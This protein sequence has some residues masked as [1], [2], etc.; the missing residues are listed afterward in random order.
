MN[1]TD[2]A[3]LK[4]YTIV[5]QDNGYGDYNRDL[6]LYLQSKLAERG[7]NIPIMPD[8]E[9][10][11]E[12]EILIGH[13]NREE[14]EA[15]YTGMFA[16][17]IMH[18]T[19]D[20]VGNKY[21]LAGYEWFSTKKAIDIA[22]DAMKGGKTIQDCRTR[23]QPMFGPAPQREGKY[24][25]LHYNILVE[26]VNWG[27]GGILEGPVYKR[28]EPMANIVLDHAPDFI[29]FCE[30][31]E[32]WAATLPELFGHK[33]S[34]VCI[35]RA[36]NNA[37]NRTLVAYDRK[38]FRLLEG[39]YENI[40]AVPSINHRVMTWGLLEERET[41]KHILVCGTHWES[42]PRESDRQKQAIMCAELINQKSAQYNAEIILMGD[43]N[44]RT[45]LAAYE[46]LVANCPLIDA[47]GD[48]RTEWSVDHIFVSK[49][50][51]VASCKRRTGM[52]QNFASD[53]QPV[54]CDFDF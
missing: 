2:N 24:R 22:C 44:T 12:F 11:T 53:H 25:A 45:G 29:C 51:K 15:A 26:W 33:Y 1:N 46:D 19:I 47:E 38:K 27:C 37:A 18:Y 3:K 21:V 31:F 28:R 9:D 5:Y 4:N 50:I 54:I 14:S 20:F 16:P 42:T 13:T 52:A 7:I 8:S 43:F 48:T 23:N 36:D 32:R 39:G 49:N 10:P 6:A 34:F 40:P 41:G 30:V 35:D 17:E